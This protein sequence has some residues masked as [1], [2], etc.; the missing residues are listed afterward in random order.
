MKKIH[1]PT[2]ISFARPRLAVFFI[3]GLLCLLAG[4]VLLWFT[5]YRQTSRLKTFTIN[6]GL[7]PT[8][9]VD[10]ITKVGRLIALPQGEKPTVIIYSD[11]MQL[12]E[13][14]ITQLAKPGDIILL[15]PM[16]KKAFL[17]DP[18][19]DIILE[20]GPLRFSE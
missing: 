20:A 3:T 6:P 19:K 8:G 7:A 15:Y 1:F 13:G 12:G 10:I 16:A 14:T 9:T 18:K 17:Y 5:S 2:V 4:G 11:K